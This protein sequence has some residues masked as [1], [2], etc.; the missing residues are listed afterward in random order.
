MKPLSEYDQVKAILI[1]HNALNKTL[2]D[3]VDSGT[4]LYTDLYEYFQ[5]DMPYGIQKARDGDPDVW[6]ADRLFEL[7]LFK[8]ESEGISKV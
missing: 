3:I 7:D 4:E 6:I 8:E 5:E 1:K 2:D